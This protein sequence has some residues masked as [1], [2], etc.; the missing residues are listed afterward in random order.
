M[1]AKWAVFTRLHTLILKTEDANHKDWGGT[2]KASYDNLY[3]N[4][5]RFGY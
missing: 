2:Q 1:L 5:L 3:S 4:K